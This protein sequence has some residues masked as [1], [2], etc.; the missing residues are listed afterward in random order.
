MIKNKNKSLV[1][2][3]MFLITIIFCGGV[4]CFN[5]FQNCHLAIAE[6]KSS[7]TTLEQLRNASISEI[8]SLSEYDGR[9]FG[10]VTNVK[11]QGASNLCWA[12][13]VINASETSILRS[14]IDASVNSSTLSLLPE[15]LAYRTHNRDA[16]PLGNSSGEYTGKNWYSSAG[17]S[18]YGGVVFSQ[19]CGPVLS[20]QSANC[21]PYQNCAYRLV[22]SENIDTLYMTA[23]YRISQ[24]KNVVAQ[25]GAVTFGY[26]NLQNQ[27][28][29]NPKNETSTQSSPHACTIIGWDDNISADK[30]VP[31]GASRDG[32]W[33]VKNS[34]SDLPYFYIS[35]D[36]SSSN[37]YAFEYCLASEYENNYFYDSV[38]D[39][40]VSSLVSI[41][42][43]GV[44]FQAQKGDNG[45]DEFVKAVNVETYG[46]DVD[47]EVSVYANITELSN[48]TSGTLVSYGSAK[49]ER[50]GY[51]TVKLDHLA[52]VPKDSYF[53]VVVNVSSQTS[54]PYICMASQQGVRSFANRGNGFN[55]I[56]YALRIKAFTITS[57]SEEG[58]KIDISSS[59]IV[60]DDTEFVYTGQEIQPLF[61]IVCSGKTLVED[62]DFSFL[63][64]NN[65]SAGTGEI[66]VTGKGDYQGEKTFYFTIKKATLQNLPN[67]QMNADLKTTK[68]LGQINLPSLWKW[69]NENTTL[70]KGTMNATAIYTGSDK[71]NYENTSCEIIINVSDSSM[72]ENPDNQNPDNPD[73]NQ[74][75]D[76]DG[77]I[78]TDKNKTIKIVCY[79]FAGVGGM[80]F[81]VAI[82]FLLKH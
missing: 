57:E 18:S 9:K 56:N 67:L 13:S 71:D 59:S 62:K 5:S 25:Y 3:I 54:S 37:M 55:S 27:F 7:I 32:G 79:S 69:E 39:S 35:Y 21:D 47:C 17:N 12:Y 82:I 29:Y 11:D 2:L 22:K 76:P 74:N 4:F 23:D 50:S 75:Q 48:P 64:K 33:L 51:H 19:W 26:N 1:I 58:D 44:I 38:N 14:G 16:D 42:N 80:I 46:L 28:Y 43:A 81:V 77:N 45:K 40:G 60:F 73:D 34:Y 65:V 24:I 10:I 36:N 49:F 70:V 66:V 78:T 31:N 6:E 68:T 63:Y 30:F 41:T 15:Q 72:V 52:K 53:A 20:N 8:A 61:N